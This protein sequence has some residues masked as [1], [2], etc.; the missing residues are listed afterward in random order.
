MS[1]RLLARLTACVILCCVA[2]TAGAQASANGEAAA[3][4]RF[5]TRAR[6]GT[7]RYRSQEA[8]IADG[9]K[10]VG[11][12]F[13]AMGEHWVHLGDVLEDTLTPERPSILI[14]V[15]VDGQPRLAGVAYTDLLH[16]GDA[17][18]RFP[19]PGMWHE[20]NGTVADESF[21][22]AHEATSLVADDGD[23]EMRLAVLHAWIWTP[24]PAG[25]FVT[26]NW[27]LPLLR[28]GIGA[29]PSTPRDALHALALAADEEGYL[30]LTLRTGLHLSAR[31]EAAASAVLA[32]Q[33]SRAT[34]EASA[35]KVAGRLTSQTTVRLVSVWSD[36]WTALERA[37]PG[38][39]AQLRALRMQLAGE[40][41]LPAHAGH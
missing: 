14:Y 9:Y 1:V 34:R 33:R 16:A 6:A 13:P 10:R 23:A 36:T 26:D 4:Q 39:A 12:E 20:H 31:E 3:T 32:A 5:L 17:R 18:P 40:L 25:V 41:A 29:A 35:V 2:G 30:L 21:P 19:A 28:L 37:L 8:A 7:N 38:R 24:N 22:L 11:V 27:S 15:N